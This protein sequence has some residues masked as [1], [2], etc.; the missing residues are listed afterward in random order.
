MVLSNTDELRPYG[1]AVFMADALQLTDPQSAIV[2]RKPDGA[3]ADMVDVGP[4]DVD[5][6]WSRYPTQGGA[7]MRNAPL[8]PG[9]FN[10]PGDEATETPAR[11]PAVTAAAAAPA[12]TTAAARDGQAGQPGGSNSPLILLG[13]LFAMGLALVPLL[14]RRQAGS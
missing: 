10:L 3:F 5:R 4:T 12:T 14:G 2:L 1:F 11:M 6:G 9:Q 13:A 7:W 8:T